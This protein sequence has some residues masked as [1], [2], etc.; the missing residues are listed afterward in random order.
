MPDFFTKR[1]HLKIGKSD[2]QQ[3]LT[4]KNNDV[5]HGKKGLMIV[6]ERDTNCSFSG[7]KHFN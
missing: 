7:I 1:R 3:I 4:E 6:V 2:M 5:G